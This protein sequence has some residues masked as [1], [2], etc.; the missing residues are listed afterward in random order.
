MLRSTRRALG[1]PRRCLAA[2]AVVLGAVLVISSCGTG[3][4]D[5]ADTV[6][7]YSGRHYDLETAFEKFTEETGVKVEFQFG[8]DAELREKIVAEGE[9]TPADAYITVD[10]GNLV[11]GANQGI[12]AP[13]DSP[14][15]DD[16]VPAELRDPDNRW[17]GLA[18]RAR[19]IVYNSDKVQPSELSTYADLADP[20]WDGRV[21]LRNSSGGYQ[22]SLVASLI[23]SYGYDEALRIVEGWKDN[24]EILENDVLIL[25]SIA[26]GLCDVGITNHYYLARKYDDDPNFPV[27]MFWPDQQSAGVHINIS[28]GGVTANAKRPELARQLLE[29]L[30]TKG[31]TAFLAGNHELPI[32]DRTQPDALL[33]E[34]FDLN[35]KRSSLSAAEMGALNAEAF[36]LMTE[37]DYR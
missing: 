9:D 30:A 8:N 4:G 12:F 5:S 7:V 19:G 24:A 6:R 18:V 26:D 1:R 36:K 25:D 20:K 15:L 3:S 23:G 27:K 22:Q 11:E 29:W 16:A 13:L 35:F 21:C 37:A 2:V 28:G 31:Q 32:N 17:F 10:A 33:Q 14:V 34:K